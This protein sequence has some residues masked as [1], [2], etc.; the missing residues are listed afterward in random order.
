[1]SHQ[2]EITNEIKGGL[3]LQQLKS[4]KK[5]LYMLRSA[6]LY[7]I[8]AADIMQEMQLHGP[9]SGLLAVRVSYETCYPMTS[10]R[11]LMIACLQIMLINNQIWSRS[12]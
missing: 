1:M 8:A 11:C 10:P 5:S 9:A 2:A 3:H 6:C 4:A 7:P 12:D